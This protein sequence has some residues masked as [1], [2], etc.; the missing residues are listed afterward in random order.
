M[1]F[2]ILPALLFFPALGRLSSWALWTVARTRSLFLFFRRLRLY[3]YRTCL[4]RPFLPHRQAP[5]ELGLNSLIG[6][7]VIVPLFQPSPGN[8]ARTWTLSAFSPQDGRKRSSHL[9][10]LPAPGCKQRSQG[11]RRR[12]AG[13]TPA[14]LRRTLSKPIRSVAS[15]GKKTFCSLL[16]LWRFALRVPALA[17]C[18]SGV[19]KEGGTV[20]PLLLSIKGPLPLVR[21]TP[22]YRMGRAHGRGCH[23]SRSLPAARVHHPH[24]PEKIFPPRPL[25]LWR[26]LSRCLFFHQRLPAVQSTAPRSPTEGCPGHDRLTAE[27]WRPFSGSR[28][29]SCGRIPGTFP[30]RRA[31]LPHG[32]G[33]FFRTDGGLP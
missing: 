20:G 1:R 30:Q 32:G 17:V 18:E 28:P 6:C 12:F 4:C 3:T 5:L 25:A 15:Q 10:R 19:S 29:R 31:F 2:Q 14:R 27:F 21:P 9:T 23:A 8:E 33:R 26:S 22:R 13:G 7:V 24:C 11:N 16:P